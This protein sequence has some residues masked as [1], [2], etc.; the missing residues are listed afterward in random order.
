MGESADRRLSLAAMKA[1]M[2]RFHLR[3]PK[4]GPPAAWPA[5]KKTRVS[6][7]FW[8]LGLLIEA[9]ESSSPFLPHTQTHTPFP[10]LKWQATRP[11][12]IS[13][14][15]ERADSPL[16]ASP[17]LPPPPPPPPQQQQQQQQQRAR[18]DD[19]LDF[20]R[21][22]A[23]V[24]VRGCGCSM[25][26]YVCPRRVSASHGGATDLCVAFPPLPSPQ[27]PVDGWTPATLEAYGQR[28][29]QQQQQQQQL[30]HGP[31]QLHQQGPRVGAGAGGSHSHSVATALLFSSPPPP[32]PAA[33]PAGAAA[34]PLGL[35][36]HPP[37]LPLAFTLDAGALTTGPATASTMSL[38]PEASMTAAVAAAA[39]AAAGGGARA[40]VA[41][42]ARRP[43]PGL[44][45][46]LPRDGDDI[47]DGAEVR[48]WVVECGV[49]SWTRVAYIDR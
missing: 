18:R 20:L 37:P 10:H 1:F 40:G 45:V 25:Y 8:G 2:G 7:L 36:V 16:G 38:S 15:S 29:Q 46:E 12:T 41:P 43:A 42:T 23:T 24:E 9:A 44:T 11:S 17:P 34:H 33:A 30:L 28:Q 39:A 31:Q 13:G 14:A 49:S 32:P 19:Y 26:V 5:V 3:L 35:T 27:A 4:V 6:S 21:R 22:L 48:F 47:E